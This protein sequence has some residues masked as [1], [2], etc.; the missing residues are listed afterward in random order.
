MVVVFAAAASW[1]VIHATFV[2]ARRPMLGSRGVCSER[3]SHAPN[4]G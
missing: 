4:C 2:P 3:E 1:N